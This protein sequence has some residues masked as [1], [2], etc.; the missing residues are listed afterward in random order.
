MRLCQGYKTK[1]R[2]GGKGGKV[3]CKL[4]LVTGTPAVSPKMTAEHRGKENKGRQGTG[5]KAPHAVF[6]T[7]TAGIK[8]LLE[9]VCSASR[10]RTVGKRHR[11][12]KQLGF[13]LL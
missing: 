5:C 13:P 11:G 3:M 8:F 2:R 6:C 7:G 4:A 1:V 12:V 9:A 10:Q